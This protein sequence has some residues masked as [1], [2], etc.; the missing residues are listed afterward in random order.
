VGHQIDHGSL[1]A[2]PTPTGFLEIVG[3]D[4]PVFHPAVLSLTVENLF[5]PIC[6]RPSF[7]SQLGELALRAA[8]VSLR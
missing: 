3:D 6:F 2:S 4:F 7:L 5:E 1:R 8:L